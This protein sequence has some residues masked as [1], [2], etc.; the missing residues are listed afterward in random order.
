LNGTNVRRRVS[1]A[2]LALA[3]AMLVSAAAVTFVALRGTPGPR[4]FEDRVRAV[5]ATL[6]CPACLDLSVADSP[7]AVAGEIRADIA[8]RLHA[9]QSAAEIRRIYVERYGARIL[10]SPPASGVTLFAWLVPA[11]LLIAGAALAASAVVRW[12]ANGRVAGEAD[13]E[14]DDVRA[15]PAPDRELLDRAMASFTAEDGQ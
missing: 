14:G 11:L 10:L 12:R 13:R 2:S 7:S 8:R 1:A 6:Q 5:A 15:L 4:T 3:A 9:G